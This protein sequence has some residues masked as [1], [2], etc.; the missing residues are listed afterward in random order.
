MP[1]KNK[2]NPHHPR[3]LG[4]LL[5]SALLLGG[6]TFAAEAEG[7]PPPGDNP[8]FS[9][10][11][12][13]AYYW[14]QQGRPDQ[15]KGAW[16]KAQRIEPNNEE[17]QLGLSAL[18][19]SPQVDP[20]A[21]ALARTLVA[22]K[23]FADAVT[24]YQQAFD[25]D[26]PPLS[27]APEYYETLA[28]T[29]A[30]REEA[31]ARIDDLLQRF[32]HF[33]RLRLTQA[34]LNTYDE[35]TRRTGIAQLEELSK[36]PA[37][38][39]EALTA[40]KQALIWLQGNQND[41]PRYSAYLRQVP[42][43]AEVSQQLRSIARDRDGNTVNAWEHL[44]SGRRKQ[45]EKAFTRILKEEP[46]NADA[47]AGL[48]LLR[49][50]QQ[51]FAAAQ[52]LLNKAIEV[53]P[54]KTEDLQGALNSAQYWSLIRRAENQR[55]NGQL[56]R[57]RR[58]LAAA[59]RLFPGRADTLQLQ[60]NIEADLGNSKR[61]I[62]LYR[63]FLKQRPNVRGAQ[64][65]L[66]SLLL[67]SGEEEEAMGL[68][69]KYGLPEEKY[70]Q[71]RDRIHARQLRGEASRLAENGQTGEA[72]EHLL[73]AKLLDPD[74]V[75][76]RHDLALLYL[77]ENRTQEAF[78][79]I[80]EILERQ[81]LDAEALFA[82]AL[83]SQAAQSPYTGLM[84]LERIPLG[85]RNREH[86]KLQNNLWRQYQLSRIR[87]LMQGGDR[88]S[89]L[90]LAEQIRRQAADKPAARMVYATA[91]A[92]IGQSEN[93]INEARQALA[94]SP[95]PPVDLRMQYAAVLLRA[96]KTD[97][98]RQELAS[99]ENARS[100]LTAKQGQSLDA[101]SMALAIREANTLRQQ[102]DLAAAYDRLRPWLERHP[103]APGLLLTMAAL[104]GDSGDSDR[105][106]A[107][108]QQVAE[109]SPDNVN[110][111]SGAAGSA[112]SSGDYA[113]ALDYVDEGL[114]RRPDASDLLALRGIIQRLQGKQSAA[115]NDFRT[116]LEQYETRLAGRDSGSYPLDVVSG[117]GLRLV[118]DE[119][120]AETLFPYSPWERKQK[121]KAGEPEWI[122]QARSELARLEDQINTSIYAGVKY[123][124]H[125]GNSG[126]SDLSAVE[127][128]MG[129]ISRSTPER[130]WG[131]ELRPTSLRAG[132]F[133]FNSAGNLLFGSTAL[134]GNFL[135]NP[136][137]FQ[138][139]SGMGISGWY[140]YK[141]WE[142]D[143]GSSPLGFRQSNVVGGINWR[144]RQSSL[145]LNVGLSH[146]AVKES[147]LSWAGAYDPQSQ[148]A[149]GGVTRSEAA[150]GI[151]YDQGQYGFYGDLKLAQL[152]GE[153]VA[154]NS[155]TETSL[156][157][158]W[159]AIQEADKEL[160]IGTRLHYMGFDKNLRYFT[161]GHGGYFSP[162]NYFSLTF[163]LE[164]SARKGPLRYRL[165]ADIG[166][167]SYEEDGAALYPDHPQ[168]Q[169][170]LATRIGS[171]PAS[172]GTGYASNDDSGLSYRI[173]AEVEYNLTPSLSLA[174]TLN[175][176][177]AN[178]F[179]EN[180]VWG[181]VRYY[182]KPR[183]TLKQSLNSPR[184]RDFMLPGEDQ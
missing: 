93:A 110:A 114:K 139:D 34:K 160:S 77:K 17:V 83:I 163:P 184:P 115:A 27:L 41:S 118:G 100:S 88:E 36:I 112:M 59:N 87:E 109:Q 141:D 124:S 127:M 30:G 71:E 40:W 108:Y 169:A 67:Q 98:L 7:Y 158:Y 103:N 151:S 68:V 74:D 175:S 1:M 24:A 148:Q 25:G 43:D 173:S 144:H 56:T 73:R 155:A 125:S 47:L 168:E 82:R 182:F 170:A 136:P 90:A 178:D 49:L 121:R 120:H 75:W 6:P 21:L 159:K 154:D 69:A 111:W 45:A 95:A 180:S 46:D 172:I 107:L 152:Q 122:E 177:N 35:K 55:R 13:Q 86:E 29:K 37:L 72:I 89:A 26:S 116:A 11:M 164:Y 4:L 165:A 8:D 128:P 171:I 54:N 101:L 176:N 2:T 38:H 167:Y 63:A 18:E 140:Q 61:A 137:D 104:Y 94:L 161:L 81:P 80:D 28:A 174:T 147:L 57:A 131:V 134:G 146:R 53:D 97:D 92:E 22:N 84:T 65:A 135:A 119:A 78:A 23:E 64:K 42:T 14:L 91:L 96:G 15:A 129:Y 153:Q 113:S 31:M 166:L 132:D 106:E 16:R 44:E 179:R 70:R 105:A 143:L 33:S 10:L 79:E 20:Q 62:T 126:R 76:I 9:L 32:P 181:Y 133:E 5:A 150:F 52:R 117:I 99:L 183:A 51:R 66:V 48:G 60:A 58:S 157:V 102:G 19:H 156:G 12:E 145:D 123:R 85:Q 138:D 130:S 149:W 3:S 50:E 162:Q 39:Q 142:F